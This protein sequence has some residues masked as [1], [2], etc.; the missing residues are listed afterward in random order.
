M[1]RF[2][3]AQIRSGIRPKKSL[4]QH[5]LNDREIIS[6][7][8][9]CSGFQ[10]F[11]QVLE[12]GPGK[13]ALTLPLAQRVSHV[14]AVE[15]DECLANLLRNMLARAGVENVTLVTYDILDWDFSNMKLPASGKIQII[16]NLPYNISTPFLEKLIDSRSYINRAVLMF[17]SE[18]AGRIISPPGVKAY[19]AL[20]LLVRYHARSTLLLQVPK[21]AFYPRPKVNSM[22]LEL[23]FERS[24]PSDVDEFIFKRVVKGAF[25]H[26]RKTIFNSLK[27]GFPDDQRRELLE[28]IKT[29]RIDPKRRAETLDMEEFLRLTAALTPLLL[30]KTGGPP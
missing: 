13:G 17:Q 12:I 21:E 24:Y 16:G 29:C 1:A 2:R 28:G 20:T 14:I 27:S 11:D 3:S 6:K 23:D 9:S 5:F 18:V 22:V 26:R 19:G 10:G 8:I 15:K 25:A 7:I 4:G 30:T